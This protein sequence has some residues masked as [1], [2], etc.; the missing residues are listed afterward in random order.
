MKIIGYEIRNLAK[1][2][3]VRCDLKECISYNKLT[4]NKHKYGIKIH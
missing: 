2:Q 4:K 1:S 3:D